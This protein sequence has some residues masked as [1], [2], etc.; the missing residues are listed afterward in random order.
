MELTKY[1]RIQLLNNHHSKSVIT[2][3]W[4]LGKKIKQYIQESLTLAPNWDW[5]F[6]G[7][8]LWEGYLSGALK[9]SPGEE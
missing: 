6:K 7:R 5:E 2:N 1:E 3:L 8:I 9:S 4:F